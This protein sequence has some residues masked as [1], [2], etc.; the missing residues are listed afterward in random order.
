MIDVGDRGLLIAMED[1]TTRRQSRRGFLSAFGGCC[2]AATAMASSSVFASAGTTNR[3]TVSLVHTHTG[4]RLTA[5]YYQAGQYQPDCLAR[6]NHLLRDF[7]TGEIHPIDPAL[8]DIL[9]ALQLQAQYDSPFAVISGYRSPATNA[10]LR[11][12]TE[13][14]AQHSMHLLGRA[15]DV[16]LEGFSTRRLGELARSL[17]RGGV[18]FYSASD[19]VHVDTG[20]VRFW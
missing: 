18:G 5:D 17:A 20:R 1:E 16:R 14:V 8:L 4:E 13:G 9:F 2:A 11:R 3:R 12:T 19:F 7:R 10:M 15:I 6:V